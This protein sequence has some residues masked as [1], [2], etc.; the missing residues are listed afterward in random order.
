MALLIEWGSPPHN[1]M[2]LCLL[3]VTVALAPSRRIPTCRTYLNNLTYFNKKAPHRRVTMPCH[4]T[5]LGLH[6]QISSLAL[7]NGRQSRRFFLQVHRSMGSTIGPSSSAPPSPRRM[8]YQ[9]SAR[10]SRRRL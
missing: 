7:L 2:S 5:F 8:T 10:W 6:Q 3:V 9:L 1:R 4:R